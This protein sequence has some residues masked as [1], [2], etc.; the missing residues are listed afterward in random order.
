MDIVIVTNNDEVF[1][2]GSELSNSHPQHG[3]TVDEPFTR[4]HSDTYRFNISTQQRADSI[5]PQ[6]NN[7]LYLNEFRS[8]SLLR[9]HVILFPASQTNT[10]KLVV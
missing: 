5:L 10:C 7:V 2:S 1:V 6:L 9:L 3:L 4:A 8:C